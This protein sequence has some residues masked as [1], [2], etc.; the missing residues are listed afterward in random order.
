[1]AFY[2]IELEPLSDG[3]DNSDIADRFAYVKYVEKR[4]KIAALDR[5]LNSEKGKQN[6]IF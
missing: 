3:C 6:E 5:Q 4:L 1:M 2:Q